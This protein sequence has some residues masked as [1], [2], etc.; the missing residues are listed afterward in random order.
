MTS[1]KSQE[2]FERWFASSK[3]V[4]AA[5]APLVLHHGT[6]GEEFDTFRPRTARAVWFAFDQ[7]YAQKYADS[8]AADNKRTIAV[9][10]ALDNPLIVDMKGG[11]KLPKGMKGLFRMANTI[12]DAVGLA[13]QQGHDGVVFKN[14]KSTIEGFSSDEIA[15]FDPARIRRMDTF[16]GVQLSAGTPVPDVL[17]H[18]VRLVEGKGHEAAKRALALQVGSVESREKIPEAVADAVFLRLQQNAQVGRYTTKKELSYRRPER[19]QGEGTITVFRSA[20]PGAT[21]R[22]GDFA[23]DTRHEAGFYKHGINKVQAFT[24]PRQDVLKVESSMGG[25]QEYVLLPKGH[26]PTVPVEHFASF[27]AFFDAVHAPAFSD[28]L[29]ASSKPEEQLAT[30]FGKSQVVD[31]A[32]APLLVFHGTP[33]A[34]ITTFTSGWWTTDMAAVKHN[35][36]EVYAAHVKIEKPASNDDLE[37]LYTEMTGHPYADEMEA[38]D[39][40]DEDPPAPLI[41]QAYYDTPFADFVRAKGFDGLIVEDDTNS[42]EGNH[43]ITSYAPFDAGKQVRLAEDLRIAS[44][45]RA[46][47][48]VHELDAPQAHQPKGGSRAV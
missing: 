33:T 21:L 30:W 23:A 5:G 48:A 16:N 9:Q 42:V 26:V 29:D 17:K 7:R 14:R 41:A 1:E 25:G 47:Q 24:V 10:L 45:L 27:R 18:L 37:R 34:G 46:R 32:G 2:N 22:P 28:K 35:G 19:L 8:R 4:D 39:L 43:L 44:A 11:E 20:P 40:E 38:A 31:D 15:V 3:I 12:E 13:L 36:A 6:A